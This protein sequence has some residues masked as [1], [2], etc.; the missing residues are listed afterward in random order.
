M[1]YSMVS[2]R[3]GLV[4]IIVT[5]TLGLLAAPLPVEAQQTEKVYRIG[6]LSMGSGSG[7]IGGLQAFRE[8]LREHGWVEG[9]NLSL[10]VRHAKGKPQR[11]VGFATEL[12]R[13]PVDLIVAPG[14]LHTLAA[15][16]ATHTIPIV[17]V[18]VADPV[19][20]GLAASLAHPGGNVTG[21]VWLFDDL[22]AKQLELLQEVVPGLS[23][24]AVLWHAANPGQNTPRVRAMERLSQSGDISLY[25]LGVYRPEDFDGAFAK[26]ISEGAEALLV[27]GDPFIYHHR[28]KIVEFAM[29]HRLPTAFS[30]RQFAEAGGLLAYA[31]S[32]RDSFRRA[33]TYVHKILRGANPADLPMERPTKFELVINLKTAQALGI[34]IP[35]TVL[36][37]ADKVI[38]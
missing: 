15:R 18:Y 16:K 19:E 11:L 8:G 10:E 30:I 7:R 2:M 22:G 35:P 36:F 31:P 13:L 23:R 5:L 9:K 33:A 17:T 6:V 37:Q 28:K 20:N 34:T 27:V 25:S 26:M 4:A 29:Q 3:L 1:T 38:K 14:S 24:V 12:V 32:I 21:I